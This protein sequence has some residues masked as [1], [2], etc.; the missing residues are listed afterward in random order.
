MKR[1]DFIHLAGITRE[2]FDGYVRRD[3]L[4]FAADEGLAAYT[5]DNAILLCLTLELSNGGIEQRDAA[6]LIAAS[7]D[8][9]KAIYRARLADGA[10]DVWLAAFPITYDGGDGYIERMASAIAPLADIFSTK[11][12]LNRSTPLSKI[13]RGI[14]RM[15]LANVSRLVRTIDARAAARGIEAEAE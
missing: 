9:R 12:S 10:P 2:R 5:V 1:V 7:R 11:V 8:L 6:S 4:P 15:A 14:S 3:V 13:E